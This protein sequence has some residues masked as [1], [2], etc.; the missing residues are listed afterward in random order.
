MTAL[1]EELARLQ[2]TP[3]ASGP[4]SVTE[5]LK[6]SAEERAG[7]VAVQRGADVQSIEMGVRQIRPDWDDDKVADEVG[8]IRVDN[9]LPTGADSF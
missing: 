3:A 9:M 2:N 1:G 4:V 6:N 5:G 8:R 7:L